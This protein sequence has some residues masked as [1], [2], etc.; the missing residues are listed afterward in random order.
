[1]A[2]RDMASKWLGRRFLRVTGAVLVGLTALARTPAAQDQPSTGHRLGRELAVPN[3]L[4]DDEEFRTPLAELIAHG[5]LLFSA[6]WTDQEGAGR[7]LTKG[8][9]KQL[10]DPGQRAEAG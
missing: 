5:K 10:A 2:V 3:H 4:R 1:M 6:N 8:T 7:P 9:G